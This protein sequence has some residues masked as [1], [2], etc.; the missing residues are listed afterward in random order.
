MTYQQTFAFW[1][2]NYLRI[3]KSFNVL[4]SHFDVRRVHIGWVSRSAHV[5]K[6]HP[7]WAISEYKVQSACDSCMIV[8]VHPG[9]LHM[10]N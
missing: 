1:N 3:L 4:P 8:A 10:I 2:F 9:I 5:Q 7:I 6:S